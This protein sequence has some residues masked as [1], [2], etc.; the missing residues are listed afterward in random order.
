MV[1]KKK[2]LIWA[3]SLG[4]RSFGTSRSVM[5]VMKLDMCKM[6]LSK[7]WGIDVKSDGTYNHNML[8]ALNFESKRKGFAVDFMSW[9]ANAA[10]L[11]PSNITSFSIFEIYNNTTTII[12][13]VYMYISLVQKCTDRCLIWHTWS[14]VRRF[15][16]G[17][18]KLSLSIGMETE[19]KLAFRTLMYW[20]ISFKSGWAFSRP[21]P[22][23]DHR[24]G[25]LLKTEKISGKESSGG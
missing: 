3:D 20:T 4:H 24:K 6:F 2:H 15:I 25:F 22:S 13:I 8:D 16:N 5:N 11:Q 1:V 9:K 18:E 14:L 21:T 17:K 19:D 7:N 23:R 12:I 10:L